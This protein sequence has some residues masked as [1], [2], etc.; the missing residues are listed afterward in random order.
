METIDISFESELVSLIF[1]ILV[2]LWF[3]KVLYV[4]KKDSW[5]LQ[6]E[7]IPLLKYAVMFWI[8]IIIK[9]YC[10]D[11]TCARCDILGRVE[12]SLRFIK[13]T[14]TDLIFIEVCSN[15]TSLVC[16]KI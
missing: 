5:T 11:G 12:M 13:P 9:R 14:L 2:I 1:S 10:N 7:Q 16:S 6:P 15:S 3:T 8:C 4:T